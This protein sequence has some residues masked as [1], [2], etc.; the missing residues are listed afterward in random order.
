MVTIIAFAYVGLDALAVHAILAD[1]M[2]DML[3]AGRFL[4]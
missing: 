2:A 3:A 1:R 4:V